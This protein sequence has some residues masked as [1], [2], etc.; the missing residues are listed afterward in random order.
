MRVEDFAPEDRKLLLP[1]PGGDLVYQC[2]GCGQV[3]GI[4]KLLYTCPDCGQVLLIEDRDFDRLKATPGPV[5]RPC[6][7]SSAT[8]N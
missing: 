6:R 8:M 3:H 5:C 7:A 4:D 2:L 1:Q